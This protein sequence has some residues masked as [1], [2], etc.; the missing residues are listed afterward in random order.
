MADNDLAESPSYRLLSLSLCKN[1]S[2]ADYITSIA[3]NLL[4]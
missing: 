4:Q 1:L 2:W 3:I